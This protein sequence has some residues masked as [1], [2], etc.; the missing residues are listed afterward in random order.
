M[1]ILCTG[2]L[3]FIGSHFV[4]AAEAAGHEV[5]ILDSLTYAGRSA[6]LDYGRRW[7]VCDI[8]D[9]VLVEHHLRRFRPDWVVNLAAESHV[10]KSIANRGAFL[11][12][13]VIGTQRLLDACLQYWHDEDLDAGFRFLHVST[14]EVYGSLA[15]TEAPWTEAS[16]YAPNNPYAAS[17]AASDHLVRAYVRCFGLPAIVTHS[18]NNYGSRQHPE[19]LVPN[20]IAKC[21][22]GQAMEIHGDGLNVRD[23]LHVVDHCEGL[24][25]ALRL[26]AVGETYNF[27]GGCERTNIEIAEL[28]GATVTRGFAPPT[29]RFVGERAGNDRRYAT[30]SFKAANELQWGPGPTIEARIVEVVEWYT[31]NPTY[32]ATYGR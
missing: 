25:A 29:V 6:N 15:P 14:D 4:E 9:Q 24:L 12:T 2:G 27:G 31:S 3:G 18:A 21:M 20:L 8:A 28:I 17:K 5:D 10:G 30:N 1:K 32:A 26:G 13:N 7:H 11:D 16:P 19:K 23:W 22:A